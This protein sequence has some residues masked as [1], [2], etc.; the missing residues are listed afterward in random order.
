M[1][2]DM[3]RTLLGCRAVALQARLQLVPPYLAVCHRCLASWLANCLAQAT[4][5]SLA[6][7]PCDRQVLTLQCSARKKT[8][9]P[10]SLCL[11]IALTVPLVTGP[12]FTHTSSHPGHPGHT[13][14]Q[15]RRCSSCTCCTG[16][17]TGCCCPCTGCAGDG[18]LVCAG[19]LGDGV[20]ARDACGAQGGGEWGVNGVGRSV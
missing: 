10:P 2:V 6:F 5:L 8:S 15:Q 4:P 20:R 16:C 9:Q 7:S 3:M 11:P 17:C 12:Y 18:A 13:R 1:G 19:V 14:A